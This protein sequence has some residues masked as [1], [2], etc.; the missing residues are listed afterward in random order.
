M[1]KQATGLFGHFV[2]AAWQVVREVVGAGRSIER[3]E[4]A[5]G[6][7]FDMDAAEDLAWN[8]YAM[9]LAFANAI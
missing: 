3:C 7:I 4:Y 8:V 6:N 1:A 9:R 5:L 2:L